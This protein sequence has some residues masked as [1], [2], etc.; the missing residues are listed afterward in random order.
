MDFGELMTRPEP[1]YAAAR[2]AMIDS[3]LRPQGV[4]DPSLLAAMAA[5]AREEFLPDELRP[6]AYSDRPLVLGEGRA[7]MPPAALAGLLSEAAPKAGE[8]A[9]VLAPATSYA[10][11]LLETLGLVVE[12]ADSPDSAGKGPYDLILVDGAI[13]AIPDALAGRLAPDGRLVTGISDQ[14]VTRLAVGRHAGGA[15]GLRRFADAEVPL[16]PAFARPRAFTF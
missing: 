6:L 15:I 12:T 7:M 2:R 16:L 4:T 10:A 5:V 14:G 3:Q 9:L 8:T 1:D 11:S 13:D